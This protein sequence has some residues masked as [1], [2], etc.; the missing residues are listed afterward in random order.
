MLARQRSAQSALGRA[1]LRPV[2]FPE[3]RIDGDSD[4]PP[5][6]IAPILVAAAGLD[7]RFDVRAVEVRAHHPHALAVAPIEFAAVLIEVDLFRRVCDA[8]RNDDLAIP[9]VEVGALDR[10]VVRL[11]TPMLVQ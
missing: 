3:L 4:A 9:A 5:G 2:D 10:T 7:Q 11:G 8:L 1:F 6:L